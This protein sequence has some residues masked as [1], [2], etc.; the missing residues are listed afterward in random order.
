MS[1]TEVDVK[2]LPLPIGI[3][4]LEI[5]TDDKVKLLKQS[6]KELSGRQVDETKFWCTIFKE[7]ALFLWMGL[8]PV[9]GVV[10]NPLNAEPYASMTLQ[11]QTSDQSEIIQRLKD[12]SKA[13][14]IS[15]SAFEKDVAMGKINV[16]ILNNLLSHLRYVKSRVMDLQMA[17]VWTGWLFSDFVEHIRDELDYFV[18]MFNDEISPDEQRL[19]WTEVNAD[20]AAFSAQMLNP[21]YKQSELIAMATR[22]ANYGHAALAT[23]ANAPLDMLQMAL[24]SQKFDHLTFAKQVDMLHS[25]A[26]NNGDIKVNSTIH[27]ILLA[28]VIREGKRSIDQLS[29]LPQPTTINTNIQVNPLNQSPLQQNPSNLPQS[30]N[31]NAGGVHHYRQAGTTF[32]PSSYPL[33]K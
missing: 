32:Y 27:P 26:W 2:V 22:L 14:Y 11:K 29:S 15:W 12:R 31:I 23:I 4:V 9:G 20:H 28:H 21:D 19:F 24:L 10:E 25:N 7:H 17:N 18:R 6:K 33:H 5:K 8:V 16:L 3:P 13:L 30:Q 1:K